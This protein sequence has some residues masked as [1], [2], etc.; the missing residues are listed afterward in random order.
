MSMRY[1]YQVTFIAPAFNSKIIECDDWGYNDAAGFFIF[2]R[3]SDPHT[4]DSLN[5]PVVY[6]ANAREVLELKLLPE[7]SE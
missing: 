4:R 6:S 1:R 7:E 3:R 2:Q 5:D